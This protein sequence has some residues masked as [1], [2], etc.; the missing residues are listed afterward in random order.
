MPNA[1]NAVE[2]KIEGYTEAATGMKK[3]TRWKQEKY[4]NELEKTGYKNQT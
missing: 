2:S 4:V 1:N 3:E